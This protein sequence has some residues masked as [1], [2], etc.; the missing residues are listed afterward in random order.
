[1]SARHR[2]N[3][4]R[5]CPIGSDYNEVLKKSK[6]FYRSSEEFEI[7][8]CNDIYVSDYKS[9]MKLLPNTEVWKFENKH[10]HR[11][12]PGITRHSN[13]EYFVYMDSIC[14]TELIG[15]TDSLATAQCI[16]AEQDKKQQTGYLWSTRI[17]TKP[18][19]ETNLWD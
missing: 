16:K 5:T 17:E 3:R 14:G 12:I 18:V 13:L 6:V 1:M 4:R 19:K 15:K 2:H 11:I 8:E 9:P 10:W 7:T